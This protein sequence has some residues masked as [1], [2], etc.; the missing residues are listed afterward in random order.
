[1]IFKISSHLQKLEGN[2]PAT[3][4]GILGIVIVKS[5]VANFMGKLDGDKSEED[6]LQ[7]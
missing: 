7:V 6:L 1:V 2:G 3:P 5:W 4:G